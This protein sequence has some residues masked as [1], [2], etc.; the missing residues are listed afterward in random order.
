MKEMTLNE[1]LKKLPIGRRRRIEARAREIRA[2]ELSRVIKPVIV[3]S[4]SDD[5]LLSQKL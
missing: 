1:Y 3:S 4:H 2:E 5:I